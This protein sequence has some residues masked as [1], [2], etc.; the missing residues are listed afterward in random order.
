[1]QTQKTVLIVDDS[2]IN[3]KILSKILSD[4][5]CV[6]EAEN[7]KE[8]LDM[9]A[10]Y[11]AKVS[12][13]MLDLVMPIMDGYEFLERIQETKTYINIP[14]IVSTGNGDRE[15]EKHA[16]RSGAWDFVSKPYDEEIIRFRLKNAIERSQLHALEQLQYLSE[17]DVLTGIYN[18]NKFA[19]VTNE[20]IQN[21]AN[22]Q[23]AFVRFDID[24]FSLVNSYYGSEE[25]DRLLI[26]IANVLSDIANDYQNLMTYARI[27]ADEF[28]FCMEYKNDADIEMV[29]QKTHEQIKKFQIRFNLVVSFGVYKV[30][31]DDLSIDIMIDNAN[32]AAKQIKGN[33]INTY[34]VYTDDLRDNLT[35]EQE[36]VNEMSEALE[37]EQFIVYLQPKYNLA[38]NAPAGAEALVRW[39]HP[40][41][42]MISPAEFVPVFERNGFIEKLDYY[43]WEHTCK[44]LRRWMD[45]GK[46]PE[47]IS[48]NVSRVN[49]YNPMLVENI[50]ELADKYHI[51]HE[52]LH[53]E[54]TES[55]YT[56]TPIMIQEMIDKFHEH[57]FIILMDDF[58]SGYSSL[59]ILK[60]IDIDILKIDMKF[61]EK[62]RIP[63][64]SESIIS[65][66]VRMAKWLNITVIAEGVES[67]EQ[68]ELLRSVGC[69]YVQGF[70][71][72]RPM[73][74]KDYEAEISKYQAVLSQKQAMMRHMLIVDDIELNRVMLQQ[75][76]GENYEITMAT[77][78]QEAIDVINK[79]QGAVDIIILDM[80]MPVMDGEEFLEYKQEHN[81]MADIPV[82]IFTVDDSPEMQKK[83]LAL[84]ADDYI[85]KPFVPEVIEKRVDNVLASHNRFREMYKEYSRAIKLSREDALTGIYN[86]ASAEKLINEILEN[87]KEKIHAFLMIDIDNFKQINDT[88]GHT[89][90]DHALMDVSRIL[91]SFF[92]ANDI[93][94]RLGGDEFI[95]FMA[96]VPTAE[97]VLGK[98]HRLL[99]KF[100]EKFLGETNMPLEVSV[101]VAL[102]NEKNNNFSILYQKA[103]IALYKSKAAGKNQV[104]I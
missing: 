3:R 11:T 77:N 48:V 56:D 53:L 34:C 45:E 38:S 85:T 57:G 49:L 28:A 63:G 4:S 87:Q 81:E 6:I 17:Y 47:P 42:G 103:D 83:T 78:G 44:L 94:A 5:Y 101:G 32:L 31:Q 90:G 73:P 86:R 46:T 1:M 59:N 35:G 104:T 27:E 40:E 16:L 23:F 97:M 93:V 25:G 54:I 43:M 96:G 50:C 55:V 15:N 67:T 64:R 30:S 61:F 102:S 76:F 20:M 91:Q 65:S 71:F 10:S 98:C 19:T 41:K 37:K 60:D 62:A 9:L 14:I 8:A 22:T 36:I 99:A 58:G 69:E 88:M 68:V 2:A 66:V 74:I 79:R 95:V 29:I 82:I 12:A 18:R 24:R 7:G 92:R 39:E 75:I 52:L 70:C 100:N 80:Q 26:Y 13:I 89:V 51:P 21:N 33:Y 72:A 84:G